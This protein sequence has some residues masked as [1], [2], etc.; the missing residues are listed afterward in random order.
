MKKK[1]NSIYCMHYNRKLKSGCDLK[2][3]CPYEEELK[4]LAELILLRE[5][6]K[7]EQKK[8]KILDK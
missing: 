6:L 3:P 2:N 8:K 4:D 1:C 5:E 7:K